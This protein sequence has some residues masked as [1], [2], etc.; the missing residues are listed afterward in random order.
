MALGQ[1]VIGMA[2]GLLLAGFGISAGFGP[3]IALLVYV[4]AGSLALLAALVAASGTRADLAAAA[5]SRSAG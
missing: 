5:P 3:G 4:L 1:L 2:T